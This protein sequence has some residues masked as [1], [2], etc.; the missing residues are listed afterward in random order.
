MTV[1]LGRCDEEVGAPYRPFH[2]ALTHYVA[3]ADEELL[4]SHVAAHGGRAW[5]AWCPPSNSVWGICRRP[6]STDPDTERYLLY[7]AA[8]GLLEEASR[9]RPVILVLDDLHWVDKPSLQLLRH[10]VANTSA[11]RLL[12]FGTYRDAELSASHPAHRSPGRRCFG[13][14]ASP[15]HLKG[16]EDTGVIAFMEEAAGHA[17]DDAGV[18]LAHQ[19]YRETDGNPFFVAEMLRNLSESGRSTRTTPGA[20]QPTTPRASSPFPT[21]CGRSSGPAW[22]RLGDDATKVLVNMRR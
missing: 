13:S 16:L 20:G 14:P 22:P 9:Q 15:L 10:V 21:A 6:Q 8:V 3:H 1:L 12:I 19:V 18:G 7:A 4:R 11:A 5:P 17:L 2:E